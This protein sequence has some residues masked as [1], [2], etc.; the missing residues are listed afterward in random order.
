[1]PRFF[2]SMLAAVVL[3]GPISRAETMSLSWEALPALP[4]AGG[5][6]KQPGVA[7]PF[8]GVHGDSLV[9]AGG[10]NFPEKMPWDGGAKVW[11]DDIWVLENLS[12]N[13]PR[14]VT[15]KTFK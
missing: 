1:M 15:D 7:S 12:G 10:A 3:A 9:V 13:S 8:V 2:S 11:W 4:P 5:Q 6:A 14:W